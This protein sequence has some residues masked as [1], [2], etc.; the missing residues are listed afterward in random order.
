VLQMLVETPRR[1]AA[2][3]ETMTA[4]QLVHRPDA[5]T[6]SAN[7]ILA[8]L[9][10]C[11]DVWGETIEAMLRQDEPTLK[12]LSPRTYI[13]KSDYPELPFQDSFQ[14][15]VEQRDDLLQTLVGLEFAGWSRGAMIKDRRHTVFTQARRLA[16][17][18]AAHIEQLKALRE[19]LKALREQLKALR[20]HLQTSLRD[21]D[22]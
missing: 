20:E 4:E 18:E 5:K 6:W 1:I 8:H 3:T 12:Y 7:D 16:L 10:A 21:K 15:F 19:Q 2:T 14:A 13:R 11:A 17:H 9:R 22:R